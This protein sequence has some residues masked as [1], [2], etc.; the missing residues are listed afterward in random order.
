[1]VIWWFGRNKVH[2][3][4]FI[5][6]REVYSVCKPCNKPRLQKKQ[7][8]RMRDWTQW[9]REHWPRGGALGDDTYEN[10][11]GTE[12]ICLHCLVCLPTRM[13]HTSDIWLHDL[14]KVLLRYHVSSCLHAALVWWHLTIYF[15]FWPPVFTDFAFRHLVVYSLVGEP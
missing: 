11:M 3:W 8:L 4:V 7:T 15:I 2:R 6:E 12:A 13:V 5:V 14:L 9:S 10:C 1:M